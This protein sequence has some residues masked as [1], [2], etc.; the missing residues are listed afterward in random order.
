MSSL[1]IE[2]WTFT[3][4][5]TEPVKPMWMRSFISY[6][7]GRWKQIYDNIPPSCDNTGAPSSPDVSERRELWKTVMSMIGLYKHGHVSDGVISWMMQDLMIQPIKL[8]KVQAFMSFQLLIP[9]VQMLRGKCFSAWAKE[10]KAKC[11]VFCL[12]DYLLE[13]GMISP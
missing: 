10:C 11:E 9:Y 3:P 7:Q 13:L 8:L 4:P 12:H 1:Q 5:E 2:I 6:M